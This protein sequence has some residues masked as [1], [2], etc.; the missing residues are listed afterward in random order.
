MHEFMGI[1]DFVSYENLFVGRRELF[2]ISLIVIDLFV[3]LVSNNSTN[4]I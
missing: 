3:H 4:N 1:Y 2:Q